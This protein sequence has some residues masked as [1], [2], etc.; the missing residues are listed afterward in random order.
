MST[1]TSLEG[2]I[3]VESWLLVGV[4]LI[5]MVILFFVNY[6]EIKNKRMVDNNTITAAD[7]SIMI[8]NIPYSVTREQVQA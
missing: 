3:L 4:V 1:D 2:V 7:F 6:Y 5:W 8:E